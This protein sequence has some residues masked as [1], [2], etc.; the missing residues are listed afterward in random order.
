LKTNA[1]AATGRLPSLLVFL[2]AVALIAAFGAQFEPGVWY[3]SWLFIPY[4]IWV[5]FAAALNGSIW[6]AN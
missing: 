3:A 1:A 6:S 2:F 4:A 5:G